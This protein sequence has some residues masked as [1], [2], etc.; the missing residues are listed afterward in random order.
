MGCL[1]LLIMGIV[2]QDVSSCLRKNEDIKHH[3]VVL[4]FEDVLCF[5]S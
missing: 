1:I 4:N 5:A 2:W 3:S